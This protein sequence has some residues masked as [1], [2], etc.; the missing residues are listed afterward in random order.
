MKVINNIIERTSFEMLGSINKV[1]DSRGLLGQV[2]ETI[3][4]GD[5][6]FDIPKEDRTLKEK[7]A[8]M[9]IQGI[10]DRLLKH[11]QNWLWNYL[12][13]YDEELARLSDKKW[14]SSATG[15]YW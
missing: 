5:A 12:K 3:D 9:M 1:M 13:N 4:F 14:L 10:R 8:T 15:A 2:V 6:R 7:V 11:D